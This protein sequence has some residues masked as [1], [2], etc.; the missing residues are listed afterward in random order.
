MEL[1]ETAIAAERVAEGI[2][3]QMAIK[4]S[5]RPEIAEF[6]EAY[7]AAEADHA[8]TLQNL[9]A[10]LS[11]ETLENTVDAGMMNAAYRALQ[12]GEKKID[13]AD[14][15]EAYELASELESGETNAVFEFL[16]THFSEDKKARIFLR[17][18][19]KSHVSQLMLQFPEKF[20]G[21]S[22]RKEIKTVS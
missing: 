17:S 1:F 3:R 12:G 19:L 6:W 8:R 10:G 13:I 15:Q 20:G 22:I 11:P 4:F 18:Q 7:A 14:L 5:H 21:A 2:Y 9:R 16:I